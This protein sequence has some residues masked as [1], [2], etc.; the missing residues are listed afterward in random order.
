[1]GEKC[2]KCGADLEEGARFCNA[3]GTP[4]SH[5]AVTLQNSFCSNCGAQLNENEVFCHACGTKVQPA[6]Q[7]DSVRQASP[8]NQSNAVNQ[9][10]SVPSQNLT[11]QVPP[12]GQGN[13]MNQR[14]TMNQVPPNGQYYTQ[15]NYQQSTNV[16]GMIGSNYIDTLS[17]A[18]G[19]NSTYYMRKF[20]DIEMKRGGGAAAVGLIFPYWAVYRKMYKEAA[21]YTAITLLC[22]GLNMFALL[23]AMQS[24]SSIPFLPV[25]QMISLIG[26]IALLVVGIVIPNKLYYKSVCKKIQM[27][28]LQGKNVL[29]PE[30]QNKLSTLCNHART[31]AGSVWAYLFIYMAIVLVLYFGMFISMPKIFHQNY[32]GYFGSSYTDWFG[33]VESGSDAED[34]WDDLLDDDFDDDTGDSDNSDDSDYD[35]DDDSDDSDSD[36]GSDEGS[37]DNDNIDNNVDNSGNSSLD[38]NNPSQNNGTASDEANGLNDADDGDFT[39]DG[40]DTTGNTDDISGYIIPDSGTRLL[41][42]ADLAGLSK[43]E[44]RYARNEIYAR[45]GRLFNDTELQEYFNSRS[46]YTGYIEPDDFVDS[47]ELSAIERKNAK[48][49][50]TYENKK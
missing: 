8:I 32:L 47:V 15:M 2:K 27:A 18:V 9:V 34:V 24:L 35:T 45:H 40:T 25:I 5:V 23:R 29:L 49:I 1:M 33:N 19:K 37:S 11:N 50:L 36:L 28:Q 13:T 44:L 12:I 38:S 16:P 20:Q 39:D 3:C 7:N 22:A 48:K 30:N 10:P 14:N 6:G 26:Q 31:S 4:V 43:D 42:K 46:W 21:V 41:K 17:A